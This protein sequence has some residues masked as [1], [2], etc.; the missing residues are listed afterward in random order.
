MIKNIILLDYTM[1][2]QNNIIQIQCSTIGLNFKMIPFFGEISPDP[3][4]MLTG[5]SVCSHGK[6]SNFDNTL[7][8]ANFISDSANRLPIRK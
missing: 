8:R 7:D 6:T 2:V 5:I 3:F 4:L 1:N